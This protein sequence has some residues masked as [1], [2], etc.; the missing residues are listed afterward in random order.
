MGLLQAQRDVGRLIRSRVAF[1]SIEEIC[2]HLLAHKETHDLVGDR[3]GKVV[4]L[5]P[6]P[7]FWLIGTTDAPYGGP[8]DRALAGHTGDRRFVRPVNVG[9]DDAIGWII[10]AVTLSLAAHGSLD[11]VALAARLTGTTAIL[12]MPTDAPALKVA[13]TKG[14]GAEV[15]LYDRE[16]QSRDDLAEQR[17]RGKKEEAGCHGNQL[18][19]AH[20][21]P[22]TSVS[23]GDC[24]CPRY[25]RG[26]VSAF[27]EILP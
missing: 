11:W 2:N 5:V 3:G 19:K 24:S 14:Y 25:L 8:I 7:H 13:A 15:V 18:L 16:S 26:I 10:I 4:F 6:W 27:S 20:S 23:E 21:Y 22:R 12:L 9:D 1:D 17:E